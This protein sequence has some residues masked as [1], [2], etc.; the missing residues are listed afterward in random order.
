MPALA[1]ICC[2]LLLL[3]LQLSP[4]FSAELPVA[5]LADDDVEV[6]YRDGTYFARF[7]Y[8]VAVSPAVALDVLTDFN[9]MVGVVPN[10]ESSE[11]VSRRENVFVVRQRGTANFGPFTFPF[12]SQRQ[13]EVLPDG[14]ILARALS[15][16]TKQMH[17]EMRVQAQG[18]GTRLEYQV[19][20]VPDRWVPSSIG[21]RFMSHEIAEQFSG[22]FREML[23]RQ[24]NSKGR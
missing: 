23:R 13:I 21:I 19:E 1:H 20:V 7:A 17:S 10:L 16:T 15:G 2:L 8:A 6:V 14:R 18:K 3:L 12:E 22:L 11:I 9:H 4:A 5:G 24:S